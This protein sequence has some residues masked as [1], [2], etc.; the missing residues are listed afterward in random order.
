VDDVGIDLSVDVKKPKLRGEKSRPIKIDDMEADSHE[1][2]LSIYAEH[3]LECRVC[4]RRFE[5]MSQLAGHYRMHAQAS[6]PKA[7]AEKLDKQNMLLEKI[8]VELESIHKLLKDLSIV[9][10]RIEERSVA[11]KTAPAALEAGEREQGA[12]L[13]SFLRENPWVGILSKR[14]D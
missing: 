4:G 1:H 10:A 13:P 7:L 11:S 14:S 3:M 9:E 2:M 12:D 8:L 5:K 6:L